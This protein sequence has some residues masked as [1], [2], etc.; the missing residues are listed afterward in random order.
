[1]NYSPKHS[2]EIRVSRIAFVGEQDGPP[3][4]LLKEKLVDFFGC[5]GNVDRAYLARITFGEEKNVSVSD[6]E[7]DFC[8]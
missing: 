1:M 4:R 7:I 5:A 2:D 8:G 6:R 3:E